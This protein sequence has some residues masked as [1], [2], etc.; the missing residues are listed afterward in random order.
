MPNED[1]LSGRT[2]TSNV[3]WRLAERLGAQSVSFIVSVILARILTPEEYGLHA[4]TMVFTTIFTVFVTSGLGTAL[5]QRPEIDDL[6]CSTA[7]WANIGIGCFFYLILFVSAPFLSKL[8]KQPMMTPILRVLSV[9]LIVGGLNSIQNAIISRKMQFKQFFK[10]TLIGTIVSAFVGIGMA[11]YGM[12]V[13]AL[14]V[15]YLSN[16]FVNTITL[17]ILIKWKPT[18][19]F[20]WKRLKPIYRFG[21]RAYGAALIETLYNNL[22]TL[23][24]GW[25]YPAEQLAFFNKGIHIP[26]LINVNTNNTIQSVIFPAYARVCGDKPRMIYMMRRAMSLGTYLIFPCMMGLGV[27]AE[28]LVSLLYTEKW[29]E[30]VPYLRIYCFVYALTPMHMVN[31]QAMLAVG[32]SDI[33]LKVEMFKKLITVTCLVICVQISMQA[34]ALSAI[35]MGI[36]ALLVNAYPVKK[37]FDYSL[38]NQVKDVL[39]QFLMSIVM[40]IAVGVVGVLHI[41]NLSK[42]LLQM[43]T[44]VS[45][46]VGL[47]VLTRN[48]DFL[49]IYRYLLDILPKKVKK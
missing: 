32:R 33:S 6:D 37:E 7:L 4:L 11:V 5:I 43:A 1:K 28:P 20:S 16:Q 35:P 42:V 17:W 29:L 44:G 38:I 40:G 39:P 30:S 12:G 45:V 19:S 3:I 21:W 48:K 8:F 14:V 46:Y 31:L 49:Y 2:I 10:A 23:L 34:T 18:F 25:Y 9:T 26:D 22:R 36:F 41:S 27:V 15:Q 47:S 24:I 13:W